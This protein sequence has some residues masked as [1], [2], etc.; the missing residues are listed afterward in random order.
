MYSDDVYDRLFYEGDE[1]NLLTPGA[2]AFFLH[3]LRLES[4]SETD[5]DS[6]QQQPK[7]PLTPTR[8]ILELDAKSKLMIALL[9]GRSLKEAAEF[10]GISTTTAW[11][12]RKRADFRAAFAERSQQLVSESMVRLRRLSVHAV[13]TLYNLMSDPK[14]PPAVRK[15]IALQILDRAKALQPDDVV[16]QR[17]E[18]EAVQS[19]GDLLRAEL[20][21]LTDKELIARVEEHENEIAA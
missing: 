11:R 13:D 10:A 16:L 21:G 1:E 20:I 3:Q 14:T 19:G 5:G 9:E 15:D 7:E 2:R 18:I 8:K 4:E 12:I 17:K 6:S